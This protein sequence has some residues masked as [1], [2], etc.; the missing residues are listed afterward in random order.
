VNWFWHALWI[1]L[2]IIPATLL[3]ITCLISISVRDNLSIAGKIGWVLVIFI[4]PIIGSLAY[5]ALS[6]SLWHST[7]T[8]TVEGT[9]PGVIRPGRDA[10]L[11]ASLASDIS[12]MSAL[13]ASGDLTDAEFEAA[14]AR[15]LAA[16]PRSPSDDPVLTSG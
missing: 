5:I 3:W 6:P 11:R 12:A 7:D 1:A 16:Q 15:L 4:L 10:A 9:P 8:A 13:H 2:L 14:K